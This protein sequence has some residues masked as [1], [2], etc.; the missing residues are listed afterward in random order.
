MDKVSTPLPLQMQQLSDMLTHAGSA[1]TLTQF[2][3][4]PSGIHFEGKAFSLQS[5][6]QFVTYLQANPQI[7]SVSID[8]IENKTTTAVLSVSLTAVYKSAPEGK[9]TNAR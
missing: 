4:L 7:E 3:M 9:K 6:K 2:S 1:M 5:F 8:K